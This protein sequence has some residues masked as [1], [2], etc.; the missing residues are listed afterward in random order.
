MV[1]ILSWVLHTQLHP[2]CTAPQ[3]LCTCAYTVQQLSLKHLSPLKSYFLYHAPHQ[4]NISHSYHNTTNPYP[5]G[6]AV[7]LLLLKDEPVTFM[8]LLADAYRTPPWQQWYKCIIPAAASNLQQQHA[9][10]MDRNG[11]M[12]VQP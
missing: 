8:V 3:A 1:S 11:R 12:R 7:Q 9:G 2:Q 10:H 5:F 6:T 4:R